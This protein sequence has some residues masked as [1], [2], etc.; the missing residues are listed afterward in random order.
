VARAACNDKG[1]QVQQQQQQQ[2]Q[3]QPDDAGRNQAGSAA[4]LEAADICTAQLRW[5][6]QV[7]H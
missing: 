6:F 4:T 5:A 1:K 2:Q 3:Q 7:I